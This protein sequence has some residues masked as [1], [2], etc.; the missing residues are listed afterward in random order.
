M[1]SH[2]GAFGVI[3]G[4]W[5]DFVLLLGSLS[6]NFWQMGVILDGIGVTLGGLLGDFGTLWRHFWHMRVIRG[7][8]GI[9][10][11]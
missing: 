3:R 4:I 5:G 2:S 10:L 1:V 6:L 9:T 11:G 8:F 7:G